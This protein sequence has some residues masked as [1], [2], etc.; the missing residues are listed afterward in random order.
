MRNLRPLLLSA[1]FLSA[2]ATTTPDSGGPAASGLSHSF[3][4]E[5]VKGGSLCF[6]SA[7]APAGSSATRQRLQFEVE[8]GD[9]GSWS[10]HRFMVSTGASRS[11]AETQEL[12]G[13]GLRRAATAPAG[14]ELA[15]L[16][17]VKFGG[18]MRLIALGGGRVEFAYNPPLEDGNPKLSA[19]E[20]EA[21]AKLLGQ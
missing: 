1:L 8:R 21:F 10:T 13:K 7:S 12:L 17:D 2:C 4:K 3:G 14:T 19:G 15:K 20:A 11:L 6:V 18:E 5:R 9:F 16:G